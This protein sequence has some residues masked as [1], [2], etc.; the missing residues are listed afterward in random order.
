MIELLLT[1]TGGI[2]ILTGTGWLIGRLYEAHKDRK[3]QV[4]KENVINGMRAIA[5]VYSSMDT[6]KDS[7]EI[8]RVVLDEISNGGNTPMPGS[9]MFSNAINAKHTNLSLG[10]EILERYDH[11]RI[12]DEFIKMCIMIQS[13]DPYKMIVKDA[14]ECLL[15]DFYLNEGVKYS[16]VYHIFTDGIEEKMFILEISTSQPNEYFNRDGIRAAINAEIAF[17]R[18]EFEKFRNIS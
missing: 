3:Y 10:R 12:D 13:G 14:K 2:L 1:S 18:S 17:I 15:K 5:K 6:L 9:R 4:R 16:E 7:Q 11:V 8:E